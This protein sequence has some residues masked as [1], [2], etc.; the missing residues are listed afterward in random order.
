MDSTITCEGNGCPAEDDFEMPSTQSMFAQMQMMRA[1]N[2]MGGI[3]M[4]EVTSVHAGDDMDC[5]GQPLLVEARQFQ[6]TMGSEIDPARCIPYRAG[7]R[8][9]QEIMIGVND[10]YTA[11]RRVVVR[12]DELIT[13]ASFRDGNRASQ[14]VLS[15]DGECRRQIYPSDL[16]R[17]NTLRYTAVLGDAGDWQVKVETHNTSDCS[18]E[19]F[20][21]YTAPT[22]RLFQ[23]KDDGRRR[24]DIGEIP[25]AISLAV[26][27][28]EAGRYA[29][30]DSLRYQAS[31]AQLLYGQQTM[32]AT[33]TATKPAMTE[34]LL[35]VSTTSAW[36]REPLP[37]TTTT[38]GTAAAQATFTQQVYSVVPENTK[39]Y[40]FHALHDATDLDCSQ[41]ARMVKIDVWPHMG[42]SLASN[43]P[44]C[45]SISS[46]HRMST[47]RAAGPSVDPSEIVRQLIPT[48]TDL[49]YSLKGIGFR[50]AKA[51]VSGG[52]LMGDFVTS[53]G[54]KVELPRPSSQRLTVAKPDVEGRV[55]VQIEHFD[56]I[57]CSGAVVNTTRVTSGDEAEG[58]RWRRHNRMY[59][60]TLPAGALD[61]WHQAAAETPPSAAPTPARAFV[62][63]AFVVLVVVGFGVV[64][65]YVF[66][67]MAAAQV[68]RARVAEKRREMMEKRDEEKPLLEQEE[69]EVEE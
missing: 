35:T 61:P 22:A 56:T 40:T 12:E 34:S 26:I 46:A 52:C 39:E 4:A 41:P 3:S 45:E 10:P 5:T 43:E 42:F 23:V 30:E 9:R 65:V 55:A 47:R 50:H 63:L 20:A 11:A 32:V 37:T 21:F 66:K 68:A 51:V 49:I 1:F 57:D 29:Y 25:D 33:A 38:T 44:T 64:G 8:L 6:L 18:G 31:M 59:V 53:F 14:V 27:N 60:G 67:A 28:E 48:D 2:R 69:G 17:P 7:E 19:A 54:V 24:V 16:T 36:P 13:A 58:S 15:R 62:A